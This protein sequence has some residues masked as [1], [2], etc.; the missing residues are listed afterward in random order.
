VR[1]HSEGQRDLLDVESV[2]GRLLKP[3]SVFGFLAEHWRELFP[4][5]LFADLFP[6][7]RDHPSVPAQVMATVITLRVLQW[8][9]TPRRLTWSHLT[10][11]GRRRRGYR[12][13]QAR[14]DRRH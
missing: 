8:C 3:G 13:L 6:S 5:E 2:A 11:V 14:F 4:D 12:S 9:R 10:C 7:G 1:G